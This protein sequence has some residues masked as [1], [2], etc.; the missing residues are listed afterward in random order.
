M[1]QVQCLMQ[2]GV[3][4]EL[5]LKPPFNLIGSITVWDAR[6]IDGKV[7]A[8]EAS[9]TKSRVGLAMSATLS[10]GSSHKGV[11]EL[12]AVMGERSSQAMGHGIMPSETQTITTEAHANQQ[13]AAGD[14]PA[15]GAAA[16][17][18]MHSRANLLLLLIGS[19]IRRVCVWHNPRSVAD[20][21][22]RPFMGQSRSHAGWDRL[23]R[24][25]WSV[26]PSIAIML[27]QSYTN[28]AILHEIEQCAL[29]DPTC[30]VSL[31][32]SAPLLFE[33]VPALAV[34]PA[35]VESLTMCPLASIE[36]TLILLSQCSAVPPLLAAYLSR[37]ILHSG[38]IPSILRFLSQ[39]VHAALRRDPSGQLAS[40]MCQLSARN[41]HISHNLQFLLM[42]EI[43]SSTKITQF[44]PDI[45]Q[46]VYALAAGVTSSSSPL[47]SGAEGE[48][49]FRYKCI[50]LFDSVRNAESS[51]ARKRMKVQMSFVGQLMHVAG[52]LHTTSSLADQQAHLIKALRAVPIA[53]D[54]TVYL[55]TEGPSC[56]VQG[57]VH[58]MCAASHQGRAH[59]TA[60]FQV[61]RDNGANMPCVQHGHDTDAK[62]SSA[63]MRVAPQAASARRRTLNAAYRGLHIGHL[64]SKYAVQ[65]QAACIV[66]VQYD[67]RQEELA[68]QVFLPHRTT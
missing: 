68:V 52:L 39:F 20:A 42:A 6:G 24:T 64:E 19:Q 1:T 58:D 26:K 33:Q 35:H 21:L 45:S 27:A 23:V 41:D 37:S 17:R 30:I 67:C 10:G 8:D 66:Q 29:M 54:E 63:S 14:K 50:Q 31:G 65:Q 51:A 25:A 2:L 18:K 12:S 57:L 16:E 60:V 11:E 53:Q 40:C 61:L 3:C 36:Q 15:P 9:G 48:G 56:R 22:E 34:S 32:T 47:V 7:L 43:E 55:P 13:A 5:I 38:S 49:N 46:R 28:A 44:K 62:Q 4:L 59:Y